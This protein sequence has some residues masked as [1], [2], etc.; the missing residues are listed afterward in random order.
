M[1]QITKR[2]QS[3]RPRWARQERTFNGI[4]GTFVSIHA[5]ALGATI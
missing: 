2:F 5:P 1:L 4:S 3:T